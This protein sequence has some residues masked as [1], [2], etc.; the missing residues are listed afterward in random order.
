MSDSQPPSLPP[1]APGKPEDSALASTSEAQAAPKPAEDVKMEP[2]EEELPEDILK[3]SAEEINT[4]TRL[5]NN[6][7]TVSSRPSL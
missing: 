6:D 5:V 2:E 1:S 4:R 7:I 3:A